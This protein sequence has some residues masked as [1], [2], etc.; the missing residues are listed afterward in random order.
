MSNQ[1]HKICFDRYLP[2]N[3]YEATPGPSDA[4]RMA[5]ASTAVR[6]AIVISKRWANNSTLRVRFL[7]GTQA[8]Q[9]IVKDFA[10]KWSD[11]ANIKFEF[12]NAP[13]AEIRIAFD[14]SDG[15][16]SYIGKDCLGI[17]LNQPTMNLGWQDEGVVLHEF[18]HTLGLIH[19]HQ[20]PEGGI[21]WN[22]DN[23]IRDLSGSPNFWDLAT[24]RHNMFEKYDRTLINGTALDKSS[25]MLYA[26]P[27]HWTMDGFQS[28][29]NEV[30]SA[31]DKQF[32]GSERGYPK[33]AAPVAPGP[34]ELPV[35]ELTPTQASI[36]R[37]GE[38]D[39][40]KFNATKAG[41]YTVETLGTTDVIMSLFG[42]N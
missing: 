35:A 11:S 38:E 2:P 23:V 5:S 21:K 28:E 31:V 18:G 41:R 3:P 15:A 42:P 13:N 1:Y 8:Q 36:G 26:I 9:K 19:E 6:A 7:G 4:E 32:I 27:K 29:P 40:F 10:P 12:N 17:A 39:L 14:P 24:I 22:E 34:T 16:W 30:L 37:P 20:N 33:A 25:I